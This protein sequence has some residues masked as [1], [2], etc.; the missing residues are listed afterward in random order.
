MGARG[1]NAPTQ[2]TRKEPSVNRYLA[3]AAPVR[4]RGLGSPGSP[5]A[6]GLRVLGFDWILLHDFSDALG[7]DPGSCPLAAQANGAETCSRGPLE[8]D[9]TP[10]P[11]AS[12]YLER[13]QPVSPPTRDP[14]RPCE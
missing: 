11:A 9:G 10:K 8:A 7:G 2:P 3:A 12:V 6:P 1:K 14:E 5:P 4:R 13:S